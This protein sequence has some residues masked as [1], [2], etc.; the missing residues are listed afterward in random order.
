MKKA[1]FYLVVGAKI[2]LILLSV[3]LIYSNTLHVPFVFDDITNIR[4]NVSLRLQGLSLNELQSAMVGG[5]SHTRPLAMLTFA[6]NYY[7]HGYSPLG[8]HIVN[9][10]VHLLNTVL[11]WGLFSQVCRLLRRDYATEGIDREWVPF[12]AS[13]LWAIHPVQTQAVTYVVQRMTSLST[14]FYLIAIL[15]YLKGRRHSGRS[16]VVYYFVTVTAGMFSMGCKEIAATLPMTLFLLEWLILQKGGVGWLKRHFLILCAGTGGFICFCW[17]QLGAN[18]LDVIITGYERFGY[19][20]VERLMTQFRVLCH[21]I[22]LIVFPHPSRLNLEYDFSISYGMLDPISTILSIGFWIALLV[23]AFFYRTKRPFFS[24]A[25]FWYI[26]TML[27]ESTVIPLHMVYEHRNYLPSIF[28]F[29]FVMDWFF[30]HVRFYSWRTII[31]VVFALTLCFWTIQRNEVWKSELTLWEDGYIKAPGNPKNAYNYAGALYRT[32]NREEA[33][34]KYYEALAMVPNDCHVHNDLAVL[35]SESGAYVE[36]DHHFK[37]AGRC[38]Y[39]QCRYRRH[40]VAFLS[41]VG[42]DEQAIE[43]IYE[44]MDSGCSSATLLNDLGNIYVKM[45]RYED[46][47]KCFSDALKIDPFF[48]MASDN[49]DSV[50]M[51]LRQWGEKCALLLSKE[52]LSIEELIVLGKVEWRMNRNESALAHFEE[53]AKRDENRALI[54]RWITTTAYELGQYEKALAASEKLIALAPSNPTYRYNKACLLSKMRRTDMALE[55]LQASIQ[56]GFKN[57]WRMEHDTDLESLR[58]TATYNALVRTL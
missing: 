35:F 57:K 40:Y 32:G 45:R 27:I 2:L 19:G 23:A 46:G 26:A 20:P 51:R 56:L 14:L 34:K 30:R 33:I 22:T 42:K 43:L 17:Y 11:V 31:T 41:K 38:S 47:L 24:I 39:E 8:F 25:I 7:F 10:V 37:R 49:M 18:P 12:A 13:F 9:I 3:S 44:L 6:L 36:A 48:D 29:L 28:M 58:A 50:S 54:F 52:Q 1:H 21:Y 16:A 5:P 15:F 4:D 55:E 53:A